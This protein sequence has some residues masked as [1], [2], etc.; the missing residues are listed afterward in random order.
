[1]LSLYNT[2]PPF[3]VS[4]SPQ[5]GEIRRRPSPSGNG[6]GVNWLTS[7]RKDTTPLVF[8]YKNESVNERRILLSITTKAAKT[9]HQYNEEKINMSVL[10]PCSLVMGSELLWLLMDFKPS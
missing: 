9:H 5:N 4:T 3:L 10:G 8:T 6:S 7:T 2:F 1:M